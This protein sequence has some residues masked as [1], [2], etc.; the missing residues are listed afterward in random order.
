MEIETPAIDVL[1][2]TDSGVDHNLALLEQCRALVAVLTEAAY[3]HGLAG[4]R[5]NTIGGHMRHLLDHQ[6]AVLDGVSDRCVDY[7][8]RRCGTPCESDPA[9]AAQRIDGLIAAFENA[10][11]DETLTLN[12]VREDRSRTRSTLARELDFAASHATHH[13]AIVSVLAKVLGIQ[14]PKDLGV[15][16]S[17]LRY[18]RST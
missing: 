3:T 12:V 14:V 1:A 15:A 10:R 13:L 7:A 16:A 6:Q 9:A 5:S 11:L 2:H 4:E 18:R 8:S 17:T